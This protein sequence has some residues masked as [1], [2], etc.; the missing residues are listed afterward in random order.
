M[1]HDLI[2]DPIIFSCVISE[3]YNARVYFFNW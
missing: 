3:K 2:Q 1:P